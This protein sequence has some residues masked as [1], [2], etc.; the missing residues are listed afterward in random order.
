MPIDHTLLTSE[1][2]SEGH[3]D[4][5]AD[6]ISDAVLDFVIAKDARAKVACETLIGPGYVVVAGEVGTESFA[7]A[8]LRRALPDVVRATL[9]QIGY[10]DEASG[11]DVEGASIE[12]R[13]GVQSPEIATQV[14]R[15]DGALGAGDQ[16]LMFGYASDETA[17]LMPLPIALAHRLVQDLAALRHRGDVAW[18]L[19][20]A[21][22]QVT[23]RYSGPEPVAIDTVVL[24][25]QHRAD[26]SLDEL[27]HTLR[28]AVIEPALAALDVPYD[29]DRLLINHAGSFVRGGP[30][31]DTGLT[32]RKIIVDTYGGSCPHGGGAFSGKDPSKVD[33]SAAY[34][35]RWVAKHIV[36]AGLARRTQVQLAYAIG[37]LRPVS[38]RVDTH[39]SSPIADAVLAVAVQRAF[40]LSP[41]GI[42]EALKLR[43]PGYLT[44]AAYGHF[45]RQ[46]FTWE[47]TPR[48]HELE[49]A[50]RHVL[51][52]PP[53]TTLPK[54]PAA[55]GP[56]SVVRPR[57][58]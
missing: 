21:K 54:V 14:E 49:D 11:F 43:R 13:L 40:D 51:A 1:S 58:V 50:V 48:L 41:K 55:D 28:A 38:V 33:R 24:A 56:S 57:V 32:G 42:I 31:A 36:A 4:K 52:L 35:A 44:T 18:L 2:V 16:G 17:S 53:A 37:S 12:V 5:V 10:D 8:D 9:R 3:P 25:S 29:R 20:D 39:G 7:P 46:E 26:V 45:G 34:A 15:S 19:P 22:S 47:Q 23:V 30:A 27:R 6:Q